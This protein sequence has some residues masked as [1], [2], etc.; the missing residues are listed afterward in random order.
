MRSVLMLMLAMSAAAA[1]AD[2]WASDVSPVNFVDTRAGDA[3]LN[4]VFDFIETRMGDDEL[5]EMS[6]VSTFP[7]EGTIYSFR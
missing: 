1:W 4:E 5:S 2:D 6:T 7:P 3:S